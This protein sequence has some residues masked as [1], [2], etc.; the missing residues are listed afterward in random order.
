[1]VCY[2]SNHSLLVMTQAVNHFRVTLSHLSFQFFQINVTIQTFF[3]FSF[4]NH[5]VL[6]QSRKDGGGGWSGGRG[7]VG[8]GVGVGVEWGRQSITKECFL[9]SW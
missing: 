1:M 6:S 5:N 8:V 3:L 4:L 9:H 7:G 2:F